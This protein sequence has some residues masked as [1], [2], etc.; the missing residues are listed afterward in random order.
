[1][2]GEFGDDRSRYV[3][4]KALKTMPVLVRSLRLPV[5]RRS[6][7]AGSAL[8]DRLVDALN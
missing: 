1:V 8:G 7:W 2:L 4:A 6:L 5:R 3:T